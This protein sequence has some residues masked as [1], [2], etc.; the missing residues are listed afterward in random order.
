MLY[1]YTFTN[2]EQYTICTIKELLDKFDT[3]TNQINIQF[4]NTKCPEPKFINLTWSDLYVY[5]NDIQQR[6]LNTLRIKY[7]KKLKEYIISKADT[8]NC[9]NQQCKIQQVG[10]INVGPASD[11]DFNI[12]FISNPPNFC[13]IF[14]LI[15]NYHKKYFTTNLDELFD[16]N[17]YGSYFKHEKYIYCLLN[18]PKD[19]ELQQNKHAFSRANDVINKNKLIVGGNLEVV[20]KQMSSKPPP[21]CANDYVDKLESYFKTFK[22]NATSDAC[23]NLMDVFEKFSEAKYYEKESY[24]SVG[25][26]L[27]IVK[28]YKSLPS[29]MYIHSILDNYG[30]AIENLYKV[31]GEKC[32][33]IRVLELKLMRFSKYLERICNTILLYFSINSIVSSPS[34]CN[35]DDNYFLNILKVLEVC[36]K[37]NTERKKNNSSSIKLQFYCNELITTLKVFNNQEVKYCNDNVINFCFQSINIILLQKEELNFK[38]C[39][40]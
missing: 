16:C 17:F 35:I 39:L 10:T 8:Y 20:G 2:V 9:P 4:Q 13:Y 11:I 33:N 14:N 36:T 28:E 5:G 6:E 23:S 18:L 26:Y 32:S 7:I 34:T 12:E 1:R 15:E 25:A 22:Q 21:K 40:D 19:I 24:R 27:D 3:I 37:I 38:T 30:F 29:S 31:I